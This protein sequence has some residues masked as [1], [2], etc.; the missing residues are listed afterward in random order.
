MALPA[1]EV[2][3]L[4]KQ[5]SKGNEDARST[6]C[7]RPSMTSCAASPG[8]ISATSDRT[9]KRGSGQRPM[10]LDEALVVVAT[11]GVD[12]VALNQALTRLT[13][14]DPRQGQIVGLR[15]FGGLTV[16]ETA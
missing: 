2:T 13:E 16:E 9:T 10:S 11:S 3:A 5:G 4:L 15:F 14:L 7:C 12:L 1:S 6:S 8:A